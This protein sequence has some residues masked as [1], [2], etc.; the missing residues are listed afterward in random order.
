[1]ESGPPK[2]GTVDILY[3]EYIPSAMALTVVKEAE[4]LTLRGVEGFYEKVVSRFGNGAKIDCP[5]QYLGRA[6]Y[7]VIRRPEAK[8]GK[9][10]ARRRGPPRG[11]SG[12]SST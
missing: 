7:V 4:E 12:V 9:T 5:R 2:P 8:V 1:M 11:R 3:P 10:A 6:V